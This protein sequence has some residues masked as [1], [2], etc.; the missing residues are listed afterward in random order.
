MSNS[1]CSSESAE[2]RT[3]ITAFLDDQDLDALWLARPANFAWL[4]G[5]SNVVDRDSPVGVAAAGYSRDA[6]FQVFTNTIEAPRLRDELLPEAFTLTATD[7]YTDSL[8]ELVAAESPT[9]AAADFDVPGLAQPDL[10]GLRQPLAAFDIEQYRGLGHETATAVEA[11]CRELSATQTERAVAV[12]VR[13]ALESRGIEAPVVLV[14]GSERAQQYRHYTP[15]TAPLGDYALVSVTAQRGGLYVSLTRTVDFD[16]PDWL[17][18]RFEAAATVEVSALA[19]TQRAAR[20]GSTAGDVF[21]AIQRAYDA[22]G[23]SDEWKQ[24]HQGGAA[25]FAGR[26]WIAT[27]T[28]PARVVAPQGYAWNPTVQGAKSEGTVLVTA[29][30]IEPLTLTDSWPTRSVSAVDGEGDLTLRR[31]EPLPV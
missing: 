8:A 28:H 13:A 26:E 6:G 4:T 9:S 14:G 2:R 20:E 7:W 5:A 24:H 1:R 17:D 15:T 30:E 25:G 23:W 27:P 3:R 21:S 12:D 10:S 29:E 18:E 31:P 19:A 16:G 11:V 22:V